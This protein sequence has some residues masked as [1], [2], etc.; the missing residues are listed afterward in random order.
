MPTSATTEFKDGVLW[1]RND[2]CTTDNCVSEKKC[3]DRTERDEEHTLG[4]DNSV[5]NNARDRCAEIEKL[6]ADVCAYD[7]TGGPDATESTFDSCCAHSKKSTDGCGTSGQIAG[8]C[9]FT[10]K[11]SN[12]R[13]SS[14]SE[15]VYDRCSAAEWLTDKT[16]CGAQGPRSST[17]DNQKTR[18][19]CPS[20]NEDTGSTN[21]KSNTCSGI[22]TAGPC[23]ATNSSARDCCAE[24]KNSSACTA[25]KAGEASSIHRKRHLSDGNEREKCCDIP[26]SLLQ[27]E[28]VVQTCCS[29]SCCDARDQKLDGK[30]GNTES[31]FDACCQSDHPAVKPGNSDRYCDARDLELDAKAGGTEKCVDDC[32]LVLPDVTT[33]SS[34]TACG[35]HLKDI[36]QRYAAL[37]TLGKCLCV[38]VLDQLGFCC[39]SLSPTGSIMENSGCASH[40]KRAESTRL[41][42]F[43]RKSSRDMSN[44]VCHPQ[45]IQKIEDQTKS[46]GVTIIK[47]DDVEHAAAREHVVLNVSGMTCTGCSRKV[48]NVLERAP[49]VSNVQVTFVSGIAEFDYDNTTQSDSDEILPRIE[50][51]T[52]FKLSRISSEYTTLDVLM[53]QLT[54]Q[55][56]HRSSAAGLVSVEKLKGKKYRITYN[57]S[58]IGA[59]S[60][61]PSDA[62][63][64][65]PT[66]DTRIVS[67]KRRLWI[68]LLLFSFAAAFTIPVVV[69]NWSENPVPPLTRDIVSL[70]LATFVQGIAVPEFYVGAI[71]SLIYSRLIE[72]DMLVVVSI[73]A[74]YV[75]SIVAFAL[76]RASYE[77][78]QG[79]FFETSS[80]LITLV[81]LGRL[82]SAWAR[83]RAVLAVSLRSLQAETALLMN[84]NGGET[85]RIDA[86]L[87]QFGDKVQ[88][89]PYSRVVTDGVVALGESTVDES[90]LT[91]E[92]TP[93]AKCIGDAVIGGTI[94]GSGTLN[95][96]LTRLPGKNSITD[97]AAMVDN[98]V[99]SKPKIQDLA[100][101]L[102]SWFTPVVLGLA[103]V[104]FVVWIAVAVTI[105]GLSG[106]EAVGVAISYAIAV[107]AISCPCALGLAV[108]MVI[109]IAGACA[110]RK[111]VVVKAADAIERGFRVTDVVFDKTGTL[112]KG[113]L[114]VVHEQTF[115]KSTCH[116][117]DTLLAVTRA[118]T[119]SNDHPV[120][121]A[122]A[123]YVTAKQNL[124]AVT[125]EKTKSIPGSGIQALWGGS[126]VLGGNPYWLEVADHPDVAQI[127]TKGMTCFCVIVDGELVLAFGLKST[128]REEAAAV[129][130]ELRRRKIQCHVVS[131]DA[132]KVVED[133]ALTLG[134]DLS[135]IVS[136]STPAAKQ[137]YV[138]RL[139]EHDKVALFCG[140][141]TNDAVAV[142]QANIGAQI[143]SVS[144]ITEAAAD[145]MLLG[146]LDGIIVFL[147]MSRAAFKRI[148][149]NFVWS[150]T[151]N[152]FAIL[153]AA[154]AF[155]TFRVPPGYAGLGE[156][157]SVLPVILVAATLVIRKKHA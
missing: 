4:G 75:Y 128:L 146:G 3:C 67:S 38:S 131:G 27:N 129:I 10:A 122:V 64:A 62:Q 18:G 34:P 127:L 126:S 123:S 124:D 33:A 36:F 91:G 105:R 61:L 101:K 8:T 86:R 65:P 107:L 6:V 115:M 95:V 37:L 83:M 157:V 41:E 15:A 11:V 84:P 92:S 77:L 16:H 144:Q 66:D 150:V 63:V 9:C 76:T 147:D 134:I 79:A 23:S 113:D 40:V 102:A 78:R 80:L 112:T 98:A 57:P 117:Y 69:L 81:L 155:V 93:V 47:T 32:C 43:R 68:M 85:T 73:T 109:V 19:G 42:A 119:E 13:S 12:S 22:N 94:N 132:D 56:M 20:N 136:R 99:S 142:A 156:I 140:D 137:E 71:K 82:V 125:I 116:D 110:A 55:E 154:G 121:T 130:S 118:L 14:G 26:S 88:I 21:K 135:Y 2:G 104:V 44:R 70:V 149:F 51:E 58:V 108:P 90:M 145:M 1:S 5:H 114:Q 138:R 39:C 53:T 120:S 54:A 97:I 28:P 74:A 49:G 141:G 7:Q 31:R 46:T 60:L 96:Q 17:T 139:Q 153:L 50:K 48:A 152:V 45:G 24:H 52:G 143:G 87:L 25:S 151:Y 89:L 148:V 59:R 106:G 72:M 100:D 29:D 30:A 35:N 133:I 111:G 103:L